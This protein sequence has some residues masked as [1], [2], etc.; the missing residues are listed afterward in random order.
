MRIQEKNM[1]THN[2]VFSAPVQRTL[3]DFIT[4]QLRQAILT[5]ELKPGQRLVENDLAQKMQTS[6]GPIRDALR[7]LE[8]EGLVTRKSHRGAFVKSLT[9]EDALEIFS[10]REA[11][12][13][14][15]IKL[16]VQNA[17]EKD[18]QRLDQLTAE[19][20]QLSQQK[21]YDQLEATELDLAF[22]YA[23]CKSSGHSR[24][25]LA[26]E[27]I[28]SQLQILILKHRYANPHD[29]ETRGVRWHT[30]IVDALRNRDLENAMTT[31][32][33]HIT[34]SIEWISQ[35]MDEN[36]AEQD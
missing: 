35:V 23:L 30:E 20:E 28:R 2:S 15:A 7:T 32:H 27:H 29:L 4:N 5:D 13:S 24:L 21:D 26:W 25:I 8:N 11:L 34:G 17:S 36:A 16:A 10:L 14:L 22:H 6:R 1:H 31:L 19:M 9:K 33:K 3:S 12:E 18:V